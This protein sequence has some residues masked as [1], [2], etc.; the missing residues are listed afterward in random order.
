MKT[1]LTYEQQRAA[2]RRGACVRCGTTDAACTRLVFKKG[3]ACCPTCGY[4]DTHPQP[5]KPLDAEPCSHCGGS[6]VE[7]AEASDG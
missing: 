5:N 3:I 1:K 7:P 2:E 6:G 4:T